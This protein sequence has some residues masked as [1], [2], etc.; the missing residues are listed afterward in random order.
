MLHLL[1]Q[2][3]QK[4][5]H[6][7]LPIRP[8]KDILIGQMFVKNDGLS[9]EGVSYIDLKTSDGEVYMVIHDPFAPE[10]KE[11]P[12]GV[13]AVALNS[14]YICEFEPDTLV[15]FLPNAGKHFR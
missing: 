15:G 4:Y 5:E 9:T 11:H 3:K 10:D 13:I 1:Q 2:L 7:S 12:E 6:R 14:S 8:V